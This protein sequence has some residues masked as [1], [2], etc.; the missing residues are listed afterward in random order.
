MVFELDYIHQQPVFSE[1]LSVEAIFRNSEREIVVRWADKNG[2]IRVIEH[3][4]PHKVCYYSNRE[5]NHGQD[6]VLG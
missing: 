2:E 6:S 3:C 1:K 4:Q 5:E